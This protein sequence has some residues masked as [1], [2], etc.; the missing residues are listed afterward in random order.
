MSRKA[1]KSPV[2]RT[3]LA[4]T[5]PTT[6][7]QNR[8]LSSKS[9]PMLVIPRSGVVAGVA[10]SL[11]SVILIPTNESFP[12]SR[13]DPRATRW[14]PTVYR[15]GSPPSDHN[16]YRPDP[17]DTRERTMDRLAAHIVATAV[18]T[19]ALA[20]VPAA[21]AQP[22]SEPTQSKAASATAT[23]TASASAT[24]TATATSSPS[25]RLSASPSPTP[26][27]S[28]TQPIPCPDAYQVGNTSYARWHGIV[29]FSVKQ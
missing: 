14:S 28:P 23:P 16:G 26:K 3:T 24:A 18:L 7:R 19:A 17:P 10:D 22:T 29:A 4:G 21:M 9:D 11:D 27:T 20:A 15:S 12:F 8:Q 25:A 13:T 5:L 2:S 6:I 1:R